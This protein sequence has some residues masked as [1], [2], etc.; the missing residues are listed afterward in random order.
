[1]N[2]A[3]KEQRT[4]KRYVWAAP[5]GHAKSTLMSLIVPIWWAVHGYKKYIILV[6]DTSHQAEGFLAAI[7]H[8]FEENDLLRTEY[9]VTPAMDRKGQPVAWRD[10]E[11]A[12]ANGVTI[13]AYGAGKA[14]RGT[15]RGESRP[16]AIVVDDLEN[17]EHVRT[18]DQRNKLDGWF[19]R[20]LLNLGDLDTDIYMVGTVIHYD[21]VLARRLEDEAWTSH[22]WRALSDD[23]TVLWPEKWSRE[24]LDKKRNEI[25]SN[26]FAGEFQNDPTR[27]DAGIFRDGWI[28]YHELIT[29]PENL[30]T[31]AGVDL[32]ISQ[33]ETADKTA[34][35][36]VALGDNEVFVLDAYTDRLSFGEAEQAIIARC[37][38][39]SLTG[40]ESNA[41][42]VAMAEQLMR[43]SPLPIREIFVHKDKVTRAVELSAH[44]EAGRVKFRK[45]DKSQQELIKQLLDFPLGSR[46]DLVDALGYAVKLALEVGAHKER[47]IITPKIPEP[48]QRY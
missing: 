1:M 39:C 7:I 35:V 47:V 13:A 15:K 16:D 14:I 37:R 18:E 5:R 33:K 44:V 46:D 11:I 42:Q 38:D 30:P 22:K 9:D 4:G 19:L 41:Y 2:A 12:L 29:V 24:A 25:G 21:S 43:R 8:E 34:I 6:A 40:I 45:G 10:R 27:G 20:A 31:F 32:A 17:D 26:A 36:I 48:E 28:R 3:I 23:G